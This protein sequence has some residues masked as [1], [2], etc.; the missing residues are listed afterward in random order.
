M[1]Q[2]VGLPLAKDLQIRLQGPT[3]SHLNEVAAFSHCL[4][5]DCLDIRVTVS[6]EDAIRGARLIVNQARIGGWSGRLNDE[7]LPVQLGVV[8]DESL[9]LGGLRAA[10][11]T[12][13][14][15]IQTSRVIVDHA[16][17]AWLLN[18][19]N[20]S[21]LVGRAWR[22]AGCQRVVGLCDYPQTLA[23]E[24]AT[25][26]KRPDTAFRF[27]F[28]GINHVGWLVPPSDVQIH[29]LLT[30]RPELASWVHDWNAIPTPWRIY[31]S[32]PDALA[33]RQQEQ[34]GYRAR[35]LKGLVDLL[36]EAIRHQD[37]ERYFAL[38]LE[39][40]PVWYSEVVVPA[41]RGLLGE[42]PVRLVVG[43]PNKGR[44]PQLD[45]N[46]QVEGWTVLNEHG[47]QP[48]PLPENARSQEDIVRFGQTRT[49]AFAATIH[50][51]PYTLASYAKSDV[52][53]CSIASHLDW[54]ELLDFYDG[55]TTL[56]NCKEKAK[57]I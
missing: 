57:R 49:L 51:S 50:P 2:L 47:V 14:F 55:T 41:M 12:W 43:L 37:T 34:P 29:N 6:L 44:L 1:Q 18:L 54:Q 53:A 35:Q 30:K 20:P 16:P 36:R 8:G 31:L 52:F 15:V 28:L 10:I 27:G 46:V 11:R 7:V 17:E 38:L 25:L 13:P 19:S 26:A 48:E 3:E 5:G 32:D 45:P 42:E 33:R 24:M 40:P 22:E 4:V 23:R 21:D 39:R 56:L 9:G